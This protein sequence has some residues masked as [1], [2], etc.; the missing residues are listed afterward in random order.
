[1][2]LK[3]LSRD[4]AS[5]ILQDS[6][7][8]FF[9][10]RISGLEG[11]AEVSPGVKNLLGFEP[12]EVVSEGRD[13]S[14]FVHPLDLKKFRQRI[15]EAKKHVKTSEI[16]RLR[17]NDGGYK[18]CKVETYQKVD[19]DN[20]VYILGLAYPYDAP[21][22]E[23]H[24]LRKQSIEHMM[25]ECAR[26]LNEA[27]RGEDRL[28]EVLDILSESL[29]CSCTYLYTMEADKLDQ[30]F[31]L[32]VR[33]DSE[34]LFSL[35]EIIDLTQSK[36]SQRYLDR[37]FIIEDQ[38][39]FDVWDCSSTEYDD[40]WIPVKHEGDIM[41]ILGLKYRAET[42]AWTDQLEYMI[43]SIADLIGMHLYRHKIKSE[44]AEAKKRYKTLF[45]Q[46]KE[47]VLLIQDGKFVE[48]NQQAVSLFG[49]DDKQ[50][51]IGK[52]PEELSPKVQYDGTPSEEATTYWIKQSEY[53]TPI[54]FDWRHQHADGHIVEC[55]VRLIKMNLDGE[56]YLQATIRDVSEEKQHQQQLRI[57]DRCVNQLSDMV[58][59][60]DHDLEDEQG[61]R[62]RYA[63]KEAERWFAKAGQSILNHRLGEIK[64][65]SGTL[66][67]EF[68]R[69]LQDEQPFSHEFH[70]DRPGMEKR[71]FQLNG[72]PIQEENGDTTHWVGINRDIT[73]SRELHHDLH[74][75][76]QSLRQAQH[77][78]HMGSLEWEI[79]T[80]QV[81][82]SNELYD[83]LQLDPADHQPTYEDLFN[84]VHPDDQRWLREKIEFDLV[85]Q[86]EMKYRYRIQN[87]A[88]EERQVNAIFE[89]E[90]DEKGVPQ[91]AIG[92]IQDVT[93]IEQ[94]RVEL[95][96]LTQ[97]ADKIKNGVYITDQDE[98]IIWAN[99]GFL[100]LTGFSMAELQGTLPIDRLMHDD[101]DPEKVKSIRD[102]R[103]KGRAVSEQIFIRR[104]ER[105]GQWVNLEVSPIV[106]DREEY[107]GAINIVSDIQA[108]K[109]AEEHLRYHKTLFEQLFEN[110]PI[111]LVLV[112]RDRKVIRVNEAFEVMFGYTEQELLDQEIDDFIVPEELQSTGVGLTAKTLGGEAFEEEAER[113]TKNG[114]RK[115]TLIAGTPVMMNG[116][117]EAIYGMYVDISARVEAE[118]AVK[119]S[120][121]EKNVLLQEVHHRVKNN[122]T[123]IKSLFELQADELDDQKAKE[124][125]R[126]SSLRIH[127]MAKVHELLYR[128]VNLVEISLEDYLSELLMGLTD[129]YRIWKSG[130][131]LHVDLDD[132][133]I[134]INQAIPLGLMMNELVSNACEH[135]FKNKGDIWVRS[136]VNDDQIQVSVRDN[137]VG[138]DDQLT[139]HLNEDIEIESVGMAIVQ[140]LVKQLNG[141]LQLVTKNKQGTQISVAFP[142]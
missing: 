23:R 35:P 86:R 26:V 24:P 142:R 115:T 30:A 39:I 2:V 105:A 139:Q 90:Y 48:C 57:L 92:T 132:V 93:E 100:R 25:F 52:T 31:R 88:G 121:E 81:T 96:R 89:A 110:S 4:D 85:H 137:G 126:I 138:L 91:R 129:M 71:T 12:E 58:M 106:N 113:V 14:R 3:D 98:R 40:V 54:D 125:L 42:V 16:Y 109:E 36:E 11:L 15:F 136:L 59:V 116:A 135:A 13:G 84:W 140:S 17:H 18:T 27:A 118:H 107:E 34:S 124:A 78:A 63:N 51:I 119:Q 72:Y 74:K 43:T 50:Q 75:E 117:I 45:D 47:C 114:K 87:A 77:L 29:G 60:I 21:A 10:Y 131:S 73:E 128:S 41:A 111:G 82:W 53:D 112:G 1:M 130:I 6:E 104:K 133:P 66:F 32:L 20:E 69:H 44:L 95:N 123:I 102:N 49:Y 103:K 56:T 28:A 99:E 120:L 79:E 97:I 37:G 108:Q 122:L 101:T 134:S 9:K 61:P 80:D 33:Q 19:E 94:A 70:V 83:L 55:R 65:T 64:I 38:S 22:L 76:R 7:I 127:T 141:E 46:S 5:T 8:V 68:I 67:G 62:I